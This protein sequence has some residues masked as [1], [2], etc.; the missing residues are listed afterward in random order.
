MHLEHKLDS[1]F[2]SPSE[3]ESIKENQLFPRYLK[4]TGFLDLLSEFEDEWKVVPVYL[5]SIDLTQI[6]LPHNGIQYDE[7]VGFVQIVWN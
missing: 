4:H 2:P 5:G 7:S 3:R 6:Q 1:L